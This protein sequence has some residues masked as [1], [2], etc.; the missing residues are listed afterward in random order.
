[1]IHWSRKKFWFNTSEIC[2]M[3]DNGLRF[4]RFYASPICS[5]TRAAVLTGRCA[6]RTGVID[7]GEALRLQERSTTI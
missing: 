6:D 1:M 3:S 2:R 4:E 7:Q 5:P